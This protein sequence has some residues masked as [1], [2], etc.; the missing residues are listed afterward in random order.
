MTETDTARRSWWRA[1]ALD[2]TPLRELR[3]FRL[4]FFGQVVSAFGTMMTY[5]VIPWQVYQLTKSSL[6]VGLLGVAEFVPLLALA[7]IGGVLADAVDRR[8]LILLTELGLTL[9]TGVLWLN[10]W[11]WTPRLWLIFTLAA[12]RAAMNALQRPAREALTPRIVPPAMIPAVAALNSLRFNI[13]SIAG[14]A[15]GGILAVK[16]GA[17][18]AYLIDAVSFAASLISLLLLRAIPPA[19]DAQK[20]RLKAIAEGL[21][22]ARSRPELMASYLIDINA[23][24]FGMPLALFPAMAESLGAGWLGWLYA[25]PAAGAFL[26]SV[27]SGWTKYI[28]R[29]GLAITIAASAWGV[30]IALFGLTHNPLLALLFL[31]LAGGADEISAIFR[32]TLWNQTIPDR[33]RGRLASVEM[34]SYLSGP[35][36]GDAESGLVASLATPRFAVVSGGVM[37]VVGSVLLVALIPAF[38]R[39]DGRE[40]R[41]RKQAEDADAASTK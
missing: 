20:L 36:L 23:M 38:L 16:F 22:Y 27:T 2:L 15:L 41:A 30:A 18:T 1:L 4:L 33:L 17:A 21:R 6:Y 5:V 19:A 3:D 35:K 7:L 29:H 24:F 28:N 40:G 32:Q 12:L 11:A 31:A 25:M 26:A 14:R 13:S 10:A 37:C 9:C 39:Y 34:L 8:R